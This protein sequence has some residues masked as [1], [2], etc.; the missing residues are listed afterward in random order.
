M[1]LNKKRTATARKVWQIIGLI[2]MA[3]AL[4][5]SLKVGLD[6]QERVDCLKWQS[7]DKKYRLFEPSADMLAQC[8]AIGVDLKN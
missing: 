6:R 3:V 7:W 5:F 2:L 4:V 1:R 8:G